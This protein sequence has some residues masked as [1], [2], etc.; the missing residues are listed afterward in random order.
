[1]PILHVFS[2]G[3]LAAE[4]FFENTDDTEIPRNAMMKVDKKSLVKQA[5][6]LD[7]GTRL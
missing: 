3:E 6:P 1:M 4:V 7:D 2:S 5:F